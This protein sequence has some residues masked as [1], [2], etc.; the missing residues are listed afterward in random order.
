MATILFEGT[1]FDIGADLTAGRVLGA[2]CMRYG[3]PGDFF[4][5]VLLDCDGRQLEPSEL[6]GKRRLALCDVRKLRR[7]L[8][9]DGAQTE[10]EEYRF[11]AGGK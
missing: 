1:E 5:F 6:V 11:A 7:K 2:A 10:A 9:D 8:R 3:D 4:R